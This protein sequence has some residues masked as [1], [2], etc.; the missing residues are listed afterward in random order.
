M[1][2][3]RE[4]ICGECKV[5]SGRGELVGIGWKRAGAWKGCNVNMRVCVCLAACCLPENKQASGYDKNINLNVSQRRVWLSQG[6]AEHTTVPEHLTLP[7][8]LAAA[9]TPRSHHLLLHTLWL[10][11]FLNNTLLG[12]KFLWFFLG[13]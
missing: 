9:G 1:V 10:R 6:E 11:F 2:G 8:V 7:E 5:A 12:E 3:H 13:D 4:E